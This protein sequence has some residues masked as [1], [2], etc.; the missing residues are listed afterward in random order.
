MCCAKYFCLLPSPPPPSFPLSDTVYEKRLQTAAD[1]FIAA[2]SKL[3]RV[4]G[5][6][7]PCVKEIKVMEH[8]RSGMRCDVPFHLPN[9][10]E[11]IWRFA[12]EV[13]T[14]QVDQFKE[15]TT[16]V[17]RLYSIPSTS[18]Q[19]QG[20]YQCEIYSGQRSIIRIYYYLTALCIGHQYQ[21]KMLNKQMEM[22]I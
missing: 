13:K 16:G 8:S 4:S 20:T 2:A 9:D 5:C 17:D 6:F 3:P 19:H 18:L 22:K 21:S 10:I 11:V 1:N 7:P 14:Q 15:V 12:E